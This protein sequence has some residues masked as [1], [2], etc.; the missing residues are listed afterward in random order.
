MMMEKVSK[1][2]QVRGDTSRKRLVSCRAEVTMPSAKSI[3]TGTASYYTTDSNMSISVSP[4]TIAEEEQST[5]PTDDVA[6]SM[7]SAQSLVP[8]SPVTTS[9]HS[10]ANV[11]VSQ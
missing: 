2:V 11:E 8:S 6:T 1:L 4:P 9:K 5:T 10:P 3:C 7:T